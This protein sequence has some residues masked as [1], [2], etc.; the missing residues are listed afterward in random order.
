MTDIKFFKNNGV[1][2]GFECS[3]HT[4][5][6]KSGKDI[7]CAA[8]S[9]LTQSVVIGLQ[10]VCFLGIRMTI[11]DDG[12]IKVIIPQDLDARK[13]RDSQVLLE[14]LYLS[15]KDLMMGYSNYIS[16]EVI[17]NVY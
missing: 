17:E 8:I 3:G 1:F 13:L 14:T 2:I 6:A 9:S 7:V 11:D 15:I 10:E 4:G 12:Y 16:M 5:Y